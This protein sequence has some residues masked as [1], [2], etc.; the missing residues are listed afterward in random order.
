VAA[1]REDD[2]CYSTSEE[3]SMSRIIT[4]RMAET[5][6]SSLLEEAH[7]GEEIIIAKE[8]KPY[9]R[10]VPLEPPTKRPLGFV[11]ATISDAFLDPLPEEELAAWG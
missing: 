5:D 6:F 1:L 8:G 9:A 3:V 10:L 2:V 11:S 4:M 7:A